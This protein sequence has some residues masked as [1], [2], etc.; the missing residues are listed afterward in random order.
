MYKELI[1]PPDLIKKNPFNKKKNLKKYK[2]SGICAIIPISSTKYKL[3]SFNSKKQIPK[4]SIIT[5]Y[6]KC[7]ACSSLQDLAIYKKK[8]KS[9]KSH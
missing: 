2:Q 1:N 6:G 8:T 3:Q 9:Y 4:K 7:G 5:H